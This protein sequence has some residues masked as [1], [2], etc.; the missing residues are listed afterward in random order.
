MV[1]AIY[2]STSEFG[3]ETG[4]PQLTPKSLKPKCEGRALYEL[5]RGV[6]TQIYPVATD[7]DKVAGDK[8]YPSLSALPKPVDVLVDCLGK[9]RAVKVVEEAANAG[10]RHI[11]F[12]PGTDSPEA[13]RLCEGKGIKVSKGCLLRHRAIS[14]PVRFISPCFYMGLGA[15]K[16]PVR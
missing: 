11:F 3:P 6:G 7:L 1:Y 9:H 15:T 4:P 5:L 13:L 2:G 10:I 12:Q 14:G 16:L 8:A